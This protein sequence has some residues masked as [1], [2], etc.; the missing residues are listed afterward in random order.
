MFKIPQEMKKLKPYKNI[1]YDEMVCHE[2]GDMLELNPDTNRYA[3]VVQKFRTYMNEPFTFTSWLRTP[4]INAKYKGASNSMHLKARASDIKTP[5]H[6]L[7]GNRYTKAQWQNIV[8]KW[9]DLCLEEYGPGVGSIEIRDSYFHIDDRE[10]PSGK[11]TVEFFGA[12]PP[13][14]QDFIPPRL[15]GKVNIIKV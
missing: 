15:R 7:N 3:G 8:G 12:V 5:R 2:G 13:D 4:A 1:T 10:R 14:A 9:H 11:F 6:G